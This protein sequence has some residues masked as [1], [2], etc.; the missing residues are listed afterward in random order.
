MYD[1]CTENIEGIHFIYISSEELTLCRD[2]LK[3]R[4]DAATTIPGTRSFHQF[5]PLGHGKVQ[6]LLLIITLFFKL[7]SCSN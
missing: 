6:P 3:K 2:T 5:D 4:L 1:Y 7:L